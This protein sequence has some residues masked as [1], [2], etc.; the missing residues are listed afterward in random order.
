MRAKGQGRR[1]Y[2][3]RLGQR[4]DTLRRGIQTGMGPW[5]SIY[6]NLVHWFV[7]A[8]PIGIISGLGAVAFMWLWQGS[9]EFFLGYLVN[10]RYPE[11]GVTGLSP[12]GVVVWTS[13]Y[14]S[15]LL[16]P[17][18]MA[19][20]GLGA[21]AIA[22]FLAPEVEGHGTDQA[23]RA[24]HRNDG[25][26]RLRVGPLKM[27]ASALTLGSGGSGGREGPTSQIGASFGSFWADFLGLPTKERRVAMAVGLGS[28]IG[29]IFK[30]PLGGALF[31]AEIFYM[32]DFE[33]EVI[34]PSIMS[35]VVSYAIFGS[36]FGWDPLFS[37]PQGISWS[38]NVYQLPLF[39]LLGL[40]CAGVGVG[41]V[42]VFYMTRSV[43]QSL[44]IPLTLRAALGAFIAG[45][46]V[47]LIY[48]LSPW[49]NHFVALSSINV[50][51]GFVQAIMLGQYTVLSYIPVL[52]IVLALAILLRMVATSLTVGSGGAAGL[53]GTS[54]VIGALLGSAVGVF[55]YWLFP[56]FGIYNLVP[57]S[58]V[59]VFAIV[60]MMAFFGGISKAP[61][62]VLVM[63]IEMVASYSI[64]IPAMLAIFIAYA[65]TG[66][67]HLYSEQVDTRMDSEAHREEAIEFALRGL[68]VG[69]IMNS[70]VEPADPGLTVAEVREGSH[71]KDQPILPVLRDGV[72]FGIV[73]R[74]D[75]ERLDPAAAATTTLFDILS[76]PRSVVSE[77][78]S[79][80]EAY[81]SMETHSA[82][83]AV[84]IGAGVEMHYRGLITRTMIL[85]IIEEGA[86]ADD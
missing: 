49:E 7:I 48:F 69:T 59:A 38:G 6:K 74:E 67:T 17:L 26:V 82:D 5:P 35:S 20:G 2:L 46:L 14:P 76:V 27:L 80:A 25:K 24:F 42:R 70:R 84:V 64:L 61:L 13:T 39:A 47:L 16:L 66:R 10:I 1:T 43:M 56:Q 63:V 33:P 23:I 37:A 4:L 86:R 65:G 9:T 50:G 21:G 78:T 79:V 73:R 11:P 19:L 22:Q 71:W 51:Y 81:K 60:G 62:A 68:R 83:V 75:M 36:V 15:I 34:F 28:G 12:G 40:L 31:S 85:G 57:A 72:W 45:L 58:Y 41:F 32:T 3:E 54:V 44:K 53:F 55:F 29:A 52:I 8:I 18:V 30:A 77:E